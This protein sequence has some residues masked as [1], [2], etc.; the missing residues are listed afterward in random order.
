MSIRCKLHPLFAVECQKGVYVD[1]GVGPEVMWVWGGKVK[2][3]EF[4]LN[5]DRDLVRG[6]YVSV[7][8]MLLWDSRRCSAASSAM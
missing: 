6:Q 7:D 5:S 3:R 4:M 2:G 1:V 8:A